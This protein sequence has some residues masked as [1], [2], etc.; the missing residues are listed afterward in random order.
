LLHYEHNSQKAR[1]DV[2][3]QVQT[4][5]IVTAIE[6]PISFLLVFFFRK[7]RMRKPRIS[8]LEE[9]LI[10][11]KEEEEQRDRPVTPGAI[12]LTDGRST[13]TPQPK[14]SSSNAAVQPLAAPYGRADNKNVH[15]KM[16]EERKPFSL[17]WGFRIA[18]WIML[19]STVA[20]CT[21]FIWSYSI[22]FGDEVCKQWITS[23]FISFVTSTFL[24]QPIKVTK[25]FLFPLEIVIDIC[26]VS[27]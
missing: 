12:N 26:N 25:P 21:Y 27:F 15:M 8:R 22:M 11:M 4:T 16:V 14:I 17:P 10:R 1:N 6:F 5:I 7:A 23:I 13:R 24:S 19:G 3:S 9:A 20:V 18:A 2:V